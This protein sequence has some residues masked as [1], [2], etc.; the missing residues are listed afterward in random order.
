MV[1]SHSI[2]CTDDSQL[3]LSEVPEGVGPMAD[4]HSLLSVDDPSLRY[5][6]TVFKSRFLHSRGDKCNG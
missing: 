1:E 4:N 3:L 2:F 6:I 5:A